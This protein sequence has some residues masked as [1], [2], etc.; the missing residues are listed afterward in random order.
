MTAPPLPYHD[1]LAYHTHHPASYALAPP[2]MSINMNMDRSYD[3]SHHHYAPRD[4]YHIPGPSQ[5]YP[6]AHYR[7]S[8][9]AYHSDSDDHEGIGMDGGHGRD[10][11]HGTHGR[12][13]REGRDG[14]DGS[15]HSDRLPFADA[16]NH[17]DDGDIDI[18]GDG[19]ND[20]DPSR[21]RK[22]D[23]Y[24][25]TAN[26]RPAEDYR[27]PPLQPVSDFQQT[28]TYFVRIPQHVR[29]DSWRCTT[30]NSAADIYRPAINGSTTG[31][32][33]RPKRR[34]KSCLS[35]RGLRI[36]WMIGRRCGRAWWIVMV[37]LGCEACMRVLRMPP[38][39]RMLSRRRSQVI[40]QTAL[41]NSIADV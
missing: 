10:G 31:K 2:G 28:A 8:Q 34:G 38:S 23:N 6:P 12:A 1:A 27:Q 29:T 30:L 32:A 15:D 25:R 35:G 7:G 36:R 40:A 41:A 22:R 9:S 13:R 37:R 3:R 26:L 14:R 21:K 39:R 19:D 17:A 24:K 18:D 20:S 16:G 5:I 11:G 33:T 4:T